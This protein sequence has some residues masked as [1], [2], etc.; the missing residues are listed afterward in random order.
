M[1]IQDLISTIINY[2]KNMDK[3]DLVIFSLIFY[4][5]IKTRNIEGTENV[6]AIDDSTLN[7]SHLAA[8]RNLGNF[9]KELQSG[10]DIVLPGNVKIDGNVKIEGKLDV[11]TTGGNI[12]ANNFRTG[13]YTL[14]GNGTSLNFY[15]SD[16]PNDK[17]LQLG[18]FE[19]LIVKGGLKTGATVD[20]NNKVLNP[21]NIIANSFR[22]G[23]YTLNG[24]GTSL[25]FYYSDNPNDKRLQLGYFKGLIVK[26]GLETGATIDSNNKVAN[27]GNIK[28]NNHI[29]AGRDL[30]TGSG[31]VATNGWKGQLIL[32]DCLRNTCEID[33]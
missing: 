20:S 10:N 28:S 14:N 32:G 22:T 30:I 19:G 15:Y 9:A 26:G 6:T 7:S 29:Y 3:K 12:K 31:K 18:Y 23:L 8:I 16:N 2:V 24:N 1:N 4:L 21:G 11:E 27:P 25:N 5:V 13:N 17:R 33:N